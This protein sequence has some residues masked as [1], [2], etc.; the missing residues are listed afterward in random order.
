MLPIFDASGAVDRT[1]GIAT[2]ISDSD[3]LQAE[4]RSLSAVTLAS[5]DL[6]CVLK[7]TGEV[8]FLN[9]AGYGLLGLDASATR[10][11][12]LEQIA[13][14]TTCARIYQVAL[15]QASAEDA[16]VEE[17]VLTEA[18]GNDLPVSLQAVRLG[19]AGRQAGR[20]AAIILPSWRAIS[21]LKRKPRST[22]VSS[23]ASLRC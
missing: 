15:P 9:P 2:D 17:M 14:A 3:R 20:Q 10:K 4:L 23:T 7:S 18:G 22:C 6:I 1:Q 8:E 11:L 12:N 16:F 19:P 21:E 5:E 13:P